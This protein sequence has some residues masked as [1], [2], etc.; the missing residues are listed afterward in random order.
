MALGTLF[1]ILI[2]FLSTTP[3][4][5]QRG[6]RATNIEDIYSYPRYRVSF[7]NGFPVSNA[8]AERWLKDGLEGGE[9][10]F[11]GENS[12]GWGKQ[13]QIEGSAEDT[14][15][16]LRSRLERMALEPN[17]SYLCLLPSSAPS[18]P[19]PPETFPTHHSN[20]IASWPLLEPLNGKCFYLRQ[21][22]FTYSYC[23]N[24]QVRQ[25]REM[26]HSHPHPP[27][28]RI[29]EEDP[30][31]EAYTLGVSPMHNVE[32]WELALQIQNNLELRGTGKRYL[33]QTWSDG[34]VCDKSG[35]GRE[36]EIQFHCSMTTTDGIL[37]VK[38]TRTCQYV[39]VLQTPRLC[40]EPGFRS[41]RDAEPVNVVHCREVVETTPSVNLG[42][43]R[44]EDYVPGTPGATLDL[45]WAD[46]AFAMPKD[47]RAQLP[48]GQGEDSAT[49]GQAPADG[50]GQEEAKRQRG[51]RTMELISSLQQLLMG[52]PEDL[53]E[54]NIQFQEGD[55]G[56]A[57][58][59]ID[60]GEEPI[61]L[62]DEGEDKGHQPAAGTAESKASKSMSDRFR[63]AMN[64][65]ASTRGQRVDDDQRFDDDGYDHED[66][67]QPHV[68]HEEL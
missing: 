30:N 31:Y 47:K 62:G 49:H 25:F 13:G 65:L 53:Q 6:L 1:P 36:V 45:T 41:E 26:A 66:A 51:K 4:Y 50:Y 21:G 7:L 15:S 43:S 28:G 52:N 8:T 24:D 35:R 44:T 64:S 67:F 37:L 11:M 17:Q 59:I 68:L 12:D 39:L 55:D 54:L 5:T 10:E 32:N 57:M 34:T 16:P 14:N 18:T 2:L 20:P 19:T 38:E 56:A 9:S 29:P 33:V 42:A 48:E 22:W 27:G 40:S 58:L 46:K 60:L 23:H 61:D 63:K 3:A